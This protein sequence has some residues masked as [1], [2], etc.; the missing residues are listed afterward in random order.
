LD[1]AMLRQLATEQFVTEVAPA[2]RD[3]VIEGDPG[4]KFYI[5]A[6]GRVEVLKSDASGANE[7]I[8]VLV[9]GDYFGELALLRNVP[10]IAT[11]RTLVPCIFLCLQR[12]HFQN[13]LERSP[14]V[15]AAILAQ[16]TERSRPIFAAF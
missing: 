7:R 1:D 13:L 3:V 14:E 9:A 2:G 15:R 8:R 10:R 16:E 6:R 12:Q 4:D 11:I 5:I